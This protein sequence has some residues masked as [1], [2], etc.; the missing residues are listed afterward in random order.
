[1]IQPRST[2]AHDHSRT[3]KIPLVKL[4]IH[5]L[6][7]GYRSDAALEAGRRRVLFPWTDTGRAHDDHPAIRHRTMPLARGLPRFDFN[8][9][10]HSVPAEN[11]TI[12]FATVPPAVA[13]QLSRHRAPG[14]LAEGHPRAVPLAHPALLGGLRA[15]LRGRRPSWSSSCTPRGCRLC[16]SRRAACRGLPLSPG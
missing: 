2:R 5:A 3:D 13:S 9:A 1:M 4:P 6:H 10:M 12:L 11:D 14:V 7:C 15:P 16:T 8:E